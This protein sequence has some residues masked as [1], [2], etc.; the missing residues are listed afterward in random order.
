[1]G[2]G[3]WLL[4]ALG[5]LALA[6]AIAAGLTV[7]SYRRLKVC[8]GEARIQPE[9]QLSAGALIGAVVNVLTRNFASAA[10][11]FIR[12]VRLDGKIACMNQGIVPL[13][14]PATVH[15]VKIEGKTCPRSIQLCAFW[16]KPGATKTFPVSINLGKDDIPG[17][18]IKVLTRGGKLNVEVKSSARLGPFSYSRTTR[19]NTGVTRPAA[20]KE[21]AT[22]ASGFPPSRE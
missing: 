15:E 3:G 11:G 10:G 8:F 20:K 9:F 14:L 19:I 1:M 2:A 17:L 12:G 6:A 21:G 7:F 22:P 5:T 16:L 18:T 13:Y 4:A